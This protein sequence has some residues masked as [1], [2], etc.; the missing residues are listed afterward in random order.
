MKVRN[1]RWYIAALLFASTVINY[2]DRQ[3]L[4]VVAPVLTKEL[5][6]SPVE[7]A[8]I[9]QAFLLAY[10]LMYVLSGPL[11]DRWGTKV[12]LS[13]FVG[14]WSVANALHV[15]ARTP[16]QFAACRF[17][18]GVGEPGNY[19]AAARITSEWYPP[20]ERAFINGL[21]NAGS[22]VGAII[23]TPLVA[24]LAI[25]YGWQF[26]F[27]FTGALGFVWL[28]F[29]LW[30]YSLP[31]RH[32]WITVEEAAW[33]RSGTVEAAPGRRDSFR[34]LWGR[35]DVW[36]LLLARFLSD[37]VWWFYLFW[38]PK[39]LAEKRS[40]TLAEIGLI[41]W[42][43]YLTADVGS[44][45][46][47]WVSGRLIGSGTS[48]LQARYIPMAASAFLMPVTI[49]IAYT[50]SSAAAM[51]LICFATFCHQVWK[52]NLMTI[53]NDIYPVASVGS[54]AG[55]VSLGSGLGGMLFMNATG[56]VVEALSYDWIFIGMGFMHPAAYI[57]CR[58][59]APPDGPRTQAISAAP[60]VRLSG[61]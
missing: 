2:I 25:N 37:P 4:S 29:W 13:V 51:A 19:N 45:L 36:G 59:M 39:Y 56:H 43:P 35:R 5:N 52:T 3:T 10:T 44:L 12:S 27:V 49:G 21:V 11:V 17:L 50:S 55:I 28:A 31:D 57:V 40:F 58:L 53:T 47:G 22:A 42:M 26:A 34:Q 16:F 23:A 32:R 9:L 6:I 14:W 33:I 18:L 8:Y 15:F 38:I 48:V 20:K 46:G 30:G 41:A 54:V 7:Y 60:Q 1:V 24:W 61:Q